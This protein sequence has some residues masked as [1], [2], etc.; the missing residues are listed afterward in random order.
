[1]FLQMG[2]EY[3]QISVYRLSKFRKDIKMTDNLCAAPLL[4]SKEQPQTKDPF[5]CYWPDEQRNDKIQQW[6]NSI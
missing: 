3:K 1:M 6:L 2:K 4:T 5:S